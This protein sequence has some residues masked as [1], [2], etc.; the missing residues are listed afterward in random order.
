ME[1][2]VC[3]GKSCSAKFS[4][5]IVTRLENDKKFYGN[6][7]ID[8]RESWCMWNCKKWPNMRSKKVI[9]N[10]MTP[11]KASELIQKI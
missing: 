8:V 10:Y 1:V 4:K 9:Y 6:K 3:T 11:S 5:Y 7:K 2:H